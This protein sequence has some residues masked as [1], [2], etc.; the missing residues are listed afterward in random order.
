MNVV[1]LSTSDSGGAGIAASR[2]HQACL[3]Q[4]INSTFVSLYRFRHHVPHSYSYHEL[5]GPIGRFKQRVKNFV[6]KLFRKKN[7]YLRLEKFFLKGRPSGFE[8]FTLPY[9]EY[10]LTKLDVIRKADVVHLHWISEGFVGYKKFFLNIG[11]K[12]LVW[13]LH[14][15]NPFTGGCHHADDS[16]G[17]IYQCRNC[18][19]VKG[20]IDEDLSYILLFE[21][22]NAMK[23]ISN[24]QF[25]AVGPSKWISEKAA[26]STLMRRF[27]HRQIFNPVTDKFRFVESDRRSLGIP[28]DKKVF[29]YIAKDVHNRRK[30][31]EYLD[32]AFAELNP[33]DYVICTVGNSNPNIRKPNL[34]QFGSINDSN[35]MARIY[36][37]ADAF[38]L[39][40]L[41]ENLPNTIAESLCCGTPVVAFDIGGIPEMLDSENGLL[42]PYKDSGKLTAAL[43]GIINGEFS[44]DR[45]RIAE[46][47][48]AAYS[49]QVAGKKYSDLYQQLLSR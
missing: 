11:K 10:N 31:F 38:I 20:T 30:G 6:R 15:M 35:K 5:I 48:R 2:I 29:L 22:I 12:K 47:A 9:S 21:K 40:S 26:A 7:P 3:D 46:K 17:Y 32:K 41:A 44:F 36:S 23:K 16:V 14:D 45:N 42:I 18:P 8:M 1:H 27:E 34:I 25:I 43:R 39:P 4:G 28:T 33:D 37:A 13:T 49:I 19:Q 24:N